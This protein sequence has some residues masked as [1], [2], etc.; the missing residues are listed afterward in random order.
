MSFGCRAN[1][2]HNIYK[3]LFDEAKTN[4]KPI[5]L[6]C[7]ECTDIWRKSLEKLDLSTI[8]DKGTS[9]AKVGKIKGKSY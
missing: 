8:I 4:E 5:P 2:P 3:R 7:P 6:D 1:P 9:K